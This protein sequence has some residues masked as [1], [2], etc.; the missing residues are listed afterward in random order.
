MERFLLSSVPLLTLDLKVLVYDPWNVY[1][2]FSSWQS[3][4]LS[5]EYCFSSPK[6]LLYIKLGDCRIW[7]KLKP[8]LACLSWFLC[9][10]HNVGSI[11]LCLSKFFFCDWFKVTLKLENP[12]YF[13]ATQKTSLTTVISPVSLW[14]LEILSSM[15]TSHLRPLCLW[16]Y[17][18]FLG[19]RKWTCEEA[20]TRMWMLLL[21]R[22][23]TQGLVIWSW[24]TNITLPWVWKFN[25]P[26][27]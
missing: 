4:Q 15:S 24:V 26:F 18:T 25:Q 20:I 11:P 13:Y 2:V 6:T 1:W 21:V 19:E 17:G 8:E 23:T 10:K 16:H 5:C 14:V 3:N 9:S 22:S 27:V 12:V 7:V